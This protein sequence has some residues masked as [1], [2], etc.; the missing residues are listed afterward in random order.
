MKNTHIIYCVIG[1][2]FIVLA[3]VILVRPIT[4]D[5]WYKDGLIY[6]YL[7]QNDKGDRS[8]INRNGLPTPVNATDLSP[9]NN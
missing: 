7:H 8:N 9:K 1:F 6:Q 5:H 3:W 4:A 2:L